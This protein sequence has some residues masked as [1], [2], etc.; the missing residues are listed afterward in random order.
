MLVEFDME[1]VI[2]PDTGA[3]QEMGD[4]SLEVTEE[5]MDQANDKRSEAMAAASDGTITLPALTSICQNH[6]L[7]ATCICVGSLE[8]LLKISL[9]AFS[10]IYKQNRAWRL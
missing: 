5:M 1:G 2:E 4:E 3:A 9:H 8:M 6:S 10:N 7:V